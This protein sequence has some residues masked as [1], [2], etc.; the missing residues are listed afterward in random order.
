M[1]VVLL[2]FVWIVNRA[3][4]PGAPAR[5]PTTQESVARANRE[6]AERAEKVNRDNLAS[7]RRVDDER[8]AKADAAERAE[9]AK[10]DN[11]AA[12]KRNVDELA[13]KTAADAK[14]RRDS[15]T[16][17]ASQVVGNYDANEVAADEALKGRYFKV[18]GD[19]DRVGKDILGNSYLTLKSGEG[20]FRSVQCFFDEKRMR[21]LAALRP[22][23]HVTVF[24]KCDGLMANVLMRECELMP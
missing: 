7:A 20:T 11:I 12:A 9:K 18:S 23:V 24:G 3:A 5:Q 2:A 16:F 21:E 14:I 22:G 17:P 10:Q 15:P 19:V 13:E 8:A 1:V 4:G 6:A